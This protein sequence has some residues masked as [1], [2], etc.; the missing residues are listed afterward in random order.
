MLTNN[1][2]YDGKRQNELAALI[3]DGDEMAFRQLYRQLLPYLNGSGMKMLKSE[4]AVAEVLQE[5]L[6]RLWVHREKLKDVK[7]P[8]AWVFRI[9]SN[10]CYRYL[11]K[12]G[13]QPVPLEVLAETQ[14]P[15]ATGGPEEVVYLRETKRMIR[16]AVDRLSPRQREIYQLSRDRGLRIHE[17]AAELG[18]GAKYVKKTLMVAV[19][20]VKRQLHKAG[21]F[22]LVAFILTFLK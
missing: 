19:H 6:I 10:E 22:Y 1:L 11:K 9:F 2:P 14:L 17:I 5:T 15:A 7:S 18:L 21:K 20:N 4:D 3:S 12:N 13:L 16:D 8:R